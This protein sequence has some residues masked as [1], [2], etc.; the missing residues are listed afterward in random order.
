[1][2]KGIGVE[3]MTSTERFKFRII[4]RDSFKNILGNTEFT[5][6]RASKGI[7]VKEIVRG[8][9]VS[10]T[11]NVGSPSNVIGTCALTNEWEIIIFDIS[12]TIPDFL[13]GTNGEL[14]EIRRVRDRVR[15]EFHVTE[16]LNHTDI[17][18]VLSANKGKETIKS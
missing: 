6:N 5:E 4:D 10:G 15:R 8:L 12:S 7:K 11:G 3:E 2:G 14:F 18:V 9:T 13:S 17:A 1:L 16:S